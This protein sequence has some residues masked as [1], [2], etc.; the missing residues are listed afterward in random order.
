MD[1]DSEE[2]FISSK[3]S[4]IAFKANQDTNHHKDDSDGQELELVTKHKTTM[5]AIRMV[6]LG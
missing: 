5:K 6:K 4:C 1:L 2:W 3:K